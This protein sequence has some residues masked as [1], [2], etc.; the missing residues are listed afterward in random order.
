MTLAHTAP[1]FPQWNPA[2]RRLFQANALL[3]ALLWIDLFWQLSQEWRYNEQ[4]Q[5][6]YLVPFLGAYL[7]YL[8]FDRPPPVL[9]G[10]APPWVLPIFFLPVLLLFPL[11]LVAATNP[12]WRLLQGLHACL[13]GAFTALMLFRT[14]GTGWLRHFGPAFVFFFFSVPWPSRL[15]APLIQGLMRIVSTLSVEGLNFCG[16]LAVQQG[17]LIR[18]PNALVGVEEACSGVRSFQ[19]ALMVGYFFG[20]WFRFSLPRRLLLLLL[21]PLSSFVLN[22]IRTLCLTLVAHYQGPEAMGRWHDPVGYFVTFG[23]FFLIALFALFLRPGHR[24]L[25][26][27]LEIEGTRSPLLLSGSSRG[28]L[29]Y[30]PLAALLLLWLAGPLLT[31]GYYRLRED[32]AVREFRATLDLSSLGP[33]VHKPEISAPT[34]ALLRFSEGLQAVWRTPEAH[35]TVFFFSWDRG[36]ISSF[37]GVHRPEICLQS[38]GLTLRETREPLLW[39]IPGA[40]PLVFHPYRFEGPGRSYYV[41]FAVWETRGLRPV[42]LGQDT[43]GRFRNVREGVRQAAR[44]SL[45]IVIT[46]GSGWEAA[47]SETRALLARSLLV[48]P[49]S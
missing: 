35:W 44:Q 42:P 39:E 25:L 4:Y 11:R 13:V 33:A 9:P 29:R 20:E 23:A 48:S 45:Q 10:V 24:P 40:A 38:A 1:P 2:R 6:G 21:G 8:R 49:Q 3:V 47:E 7:L 32:R 30:P 31:E 36:N 46:G 22:L 26:A 17:N 27:S 43:L 28:L 19:S 41:Y 16:I 12:D 18:L 34:R 15:E 37:A 14:G 5:F